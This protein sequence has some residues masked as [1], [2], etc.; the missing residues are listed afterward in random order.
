MEYDTRAF[1]QNVQRGT[2]SLVEALQKYASDKKENDFLTSTFETMAASR[3][4]R[5]MPVDP[6]ILQKFHS[7]SLGAKRGIVSAMG[8]E[9]A[10]Q[11]HQA[12][13]ENYRNQSEAHRAQ[14]ENYRAQAAQRDASAKRIGEDRQNME[15]YAQAYAQGDESA[16]EPFL[17]PLNEPTEEDYS[18]FIQSGTPEGRAKYATSQFPG[19]LADRNFAKNAAALQAL[20]TSTARVGVAQKVV[21]ADGWGYVPT[22]PKQ[23]QLI[24]LGTPDATPAPVLKPTD[25][26][27]VY[28][29]SDAKGNPKIFQPRSVPAKVSPMAQLAIDSKTRELASIDGR[30]ADLEKQ[31]AEHGLKSKNGPDWNPFADTLEEKLKELY[32]QKAK[33]ETEL[34]TLRKNKSNTTDTAPDAGG[35][36][37]NSAPVISFD[38]FQ[39]YK[40]K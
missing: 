11:T 38:D 17:D 37:T 22:G 12:Q 32:N 13:M 28:S 20:G 34:N 7:G 16:L 21:G 4:K 19:A 9:M 39:K 30:I 25:V 8:T 29:Y 33:K 2:D 36:K 6:D 1:G 10:E 40:S 26:P 3:A 24:R 27:G 23:G 18:R 35:S 5:G 15:G 14:M 31:S